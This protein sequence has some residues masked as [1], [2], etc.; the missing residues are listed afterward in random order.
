MYLTAWCPFCTRARALLDKKGVPYD[1]IDVD[2]DFEKR[3][4]LSEVTG[5]RTV[6]QIFI[7]D[8][9]IAFEFSPLRGDLVYLATKPGLVEAYDVDTGARISEVGFI[10]IPDVYEQPRPTLDVVFKQ[11]I[12]RFNFTLKLQNIIDSPVKF[13]Q[14]EPATGDL[15]TRERYLLGRRVSLSMSIDLN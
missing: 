8:E 6:P 11:G 2:G 9:P 12:D 4:W 3:R 5:Q 7:G 10:G 14:E 15:L 1:P 13:T